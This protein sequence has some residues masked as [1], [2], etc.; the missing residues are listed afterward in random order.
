VGVLGPVGVGVRMFV[1][2]V[3]VLMCGVGVR[4]AQ[5]AVAVFVRMR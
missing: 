2:D 4:V 5:L 1:L 3:A